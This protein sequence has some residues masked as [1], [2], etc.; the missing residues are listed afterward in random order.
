MGARNGNIVGL[1]GGRLIAFKRQK[2]LTLL[3]PLAFQH[4]RQAMNHYIQET[5]D[6]QAENSD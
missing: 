2:L 5:A 6:H 4:D 1:G 3:S